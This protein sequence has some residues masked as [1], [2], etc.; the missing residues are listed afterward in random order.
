MSPPKRPAAA[1]GSSTGSSDSEVKALLARYRCPTPMHALRTLFIGH[2]A[3]PR[4]DASPMATVQQAW[5]GELPEFATAVDA[6]ELFGVLL[7]GL[8]NRLS[9]HQSSRNPFRLSRFEVKPERAALLELAQVRV[10]ELE[11]FVDGLFGLEA[12]ISLPEK[13]HEALSKLADLNAM[14]AGA[15]ELLADPS[16]PARP[17]DLKLLL[18]NLQ[19]LSLAADDQINRILQ[20]CKRARAQHL[21]ALASVQSSRA[22]FDGLQ[23][24]VDASADDLGDVDTDAGDDDGEPDIVKSPLSQGVTRHGVTVQVDIYRGDS[25][26]ILEIVDAE[27]ASHVWG[28]QFETDEHALAAA[29]AALDEQPLEF[30]GQAAGRP[31]N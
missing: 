5:G 25:R 19:Q 27:R 6:E 21:D 16:K 9:E 31:L 23:E 1:T 26:W 28:E 15:A 4:L 24:G 17:D 7:R 2:I 18:R 30:F 20:S 29:L 3:S 12:E 10:Q 13:A 22:A 11:G 14:F 8:W